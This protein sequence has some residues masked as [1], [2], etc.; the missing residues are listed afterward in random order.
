MKLLKKNLVQE[1]K[2]LVVEAVVTEV[3]VNREEKVVSEEVNVEKDQETEIV[4][5][6]QASEVEEEEMEEIILVLQE[7]PDLEVKDLREAEIEEVLESLSIKE[8]KV[9]FKI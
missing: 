4:T 5:E 1:I 8:K 9:V 6:V 7:I 2:D 3:L